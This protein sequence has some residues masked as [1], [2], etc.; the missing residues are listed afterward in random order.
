[1]QAGILTFGTIEQ[2]R[3]RGR[4]LD[5]RR[6]QPTENWCPLLAVR[7]VAR[8]RNFLHTNAHLD[9]LR[10]QLRI[11]QTGDKG[12]I[13]AEQEALQGVVHQRVLTHPVGDYREPNHA[14]ARAAGGQQCL[15]E[16]R[17]RVYI[18]GRW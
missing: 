2:G 12:N 11:T 17:R 3:Y 14:L 5:Y 4:F 8:G 7:F 16:M 6:F 9:G 15:D 10:V 18:D 1:M 13:E